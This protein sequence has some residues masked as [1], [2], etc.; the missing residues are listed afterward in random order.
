MRRSEG[1]QRIRPLPRGKGSKTI[2]IGKVPRATIDFPLSVRD[3]EE[4][5]VK[6]FFIVAA[7][8]SP[9]N[10]IVTSVDCNRVVECGDLSFGS[11]YK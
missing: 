3:E 1:C 11:T 2:S 6:H 10:L 9:C 7:A 4:T 5:V 8:T